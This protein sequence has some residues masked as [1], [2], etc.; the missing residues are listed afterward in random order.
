MH[1]F[2]NWDVFGVFYWKNSLN[3]VQYLVIGYVK[4]FNFKDMLQILL[5]RSLINYQECRKISY[6]SAS[7]PRQIFSVLSLFNIIIFII[8]VT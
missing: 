3:E 8:S 7:F 1:I 5:R 6:F 2:K 4:P